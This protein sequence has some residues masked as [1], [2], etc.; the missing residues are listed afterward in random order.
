MVAL[1]LS[2]QCPM[3]ISPQQFRSFQLLGDDGCRLRSNYSNNSRLNT[4]LSAC[5]A[6]LTPD[7]PVADR[8]S[9]I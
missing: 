2:A 9:I 5:L 7:P 3:I 4:F 8:L 6:G 1:V